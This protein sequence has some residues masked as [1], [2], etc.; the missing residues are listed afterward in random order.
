[1][2]DKQKMTQNVN[3][4]NIYLIVLDCDSVIE[5]INNA[6]LKLSKQMKF[7]HATFLFLA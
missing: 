4:N 3:T 7:Y 6:D 2:S 5:P 1:M